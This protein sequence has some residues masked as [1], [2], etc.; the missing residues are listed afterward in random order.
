MGYVSIYHSFFLIIYICI[1]YYQLWDIK[2]SC[3]YSTATVIIYFPGDNDVAG[4]AKET[5]KAAVDDEAVQDQNDKV[6]IFNI[7]Y[8]NYWILN[9]M[10]NL[11]QAMICKF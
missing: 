1:F 7:P 4:T 8:N 5:H 10:I 11:L 6:N 9:G 3:I 2:R